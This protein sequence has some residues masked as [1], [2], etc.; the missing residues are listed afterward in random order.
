[1][2]EIEHIK[3]IEEEVANHVQKAKVKAEKKIGDARLLREKVLAEKTAEANAHIEK[4]L[5]KVKEDAEKEASETLKGID[6]EKRR[7]DSNAS[8]N[9]PAAVELIVNELRNIN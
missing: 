5:K 8:K 9:L 1:M 3:K 4:Q 2:E 6:S 7:I